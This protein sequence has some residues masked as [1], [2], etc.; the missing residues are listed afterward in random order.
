MCTWFPL[1]RSLVSY[2]NRSFSLSPFSRFLCAHL[3]GG[4]VAAL[5][6]LVKKG[7]ADLSALD[8]R[9]V[10]PLLAACRRAQTEVV[11]WLMAQESVGWDVPDVSGTT[12][13]MVACAQGNLSLVC[14]VLGQYEFVIFTSFIITWNDISRVVYK[15]RC[16]CT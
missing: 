5:D 9:H 4:H 8:H 6:C 15:W 1:Y 14:T 3:Q 13:F 10:T 16:M 12:P 7:H 2:F 11:D